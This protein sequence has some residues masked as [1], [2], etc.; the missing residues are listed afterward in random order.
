MRYITRT[1]EGE[2]HQP[3]INWNAIGGWFDVS[4]YIRYGDHNWMVFFEAR[5]WK[6]RFRFHRWS[7]IEMNKLM[8]GLA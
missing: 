5:R 3:G 8:R 4:L 2:E 7:T 1:Q 6:A